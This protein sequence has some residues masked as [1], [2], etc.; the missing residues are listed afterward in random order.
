M[1]WY[2]LFECENARWFSRVFVRLLDQSEAGIERA[3]ESSEEVLPRRNV[4]GQGHL[5][6]K[7]PAPKERIRSSSHRFLTQTPIVKTSSSPLLIHSKT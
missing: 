4:S 5:K 7:I 1:W 2:S 3:N 6:G